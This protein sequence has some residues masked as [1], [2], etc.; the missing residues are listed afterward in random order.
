M[1]PLVTPEIDID[2]RTAEEPPC[3]VIIHNDDVTP[4]DF[5]IHIL[6]SIFLLHLLG[7]IQVMYAAH[8]HGSAHVCTCPRNIAQRRVSEAHMA[9][10]IA[11]FPLTF[12][13]EEE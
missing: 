5:V 1:H 8:H 13:I 6:Q 3:R 7:A 4:M 2:Q 12:T 10:R 11:K 9:A